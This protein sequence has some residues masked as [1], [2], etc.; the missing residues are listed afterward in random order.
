[1]KD[2]TRAIDLSVIDYEQWVQ[3]LFGH[4]VPKDDLSD[5]HWNDG[6]DF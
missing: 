3:T 6:L 1:M 4:P 2:D 5:P